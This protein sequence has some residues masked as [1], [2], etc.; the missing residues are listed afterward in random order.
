MKNETLAKFICHN[1]CV[2][3][4]EMHESGVDPTCWSEWQAV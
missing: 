1:L 3:I 2:V 4:Q